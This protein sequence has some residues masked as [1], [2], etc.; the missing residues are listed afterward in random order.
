MSK[1]KDRRIRRLQC[2][3]IWPRV[4]SLVI[5]EIIVFALAVFL[6]WCTITAIGVT[7][8]LQS[9]QEC[10]SVVK[11]VN[12]YYKTDTADVLTSRIDS[13]V[14]TSNSLNSV[15]L[16]EGQ[17]IL[18]LFPGLEEDF[19]EEAQKDFRKNGIIRFTD[20]DYDRVMFFGVQKSIESDKTQTDQTP[21]APP[22]E[23]QQFKEAPR[24]LVYTFSVSDEEGRNQPFIVDLRNIIRSMRF[25][26]IDNYELS[27]WAGVPVLDLPITHTITSVN[28]SKNW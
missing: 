4:L 22:V 9:E 17:G 25:D 24:G 10:R 13:I 8:I 2:L 23:N 15:T 27:T 3:P 11:T 16:D 18:T 19:D 26:V 21:P 5:F 12:E 28:G 7:V 14:D 1:K 6:C 20:P